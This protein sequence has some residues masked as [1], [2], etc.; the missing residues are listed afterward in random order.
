M[1]YRES[2]MDGISRKLR[3]LTVALHGELGAVATEYGLILTLV[4][5]VI[6]VAITLYGGAVLG[7]F[8]QAPDKFP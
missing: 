1:A 4:A 3:R 6:V 5:V 8:Q 7:L 2:I